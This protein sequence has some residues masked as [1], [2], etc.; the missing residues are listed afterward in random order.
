MG[1]TCRIVRFGEALIAR[2]GAVAAGLALA[3]AALLLGAPDA[4]AATY[5]VGETTDGIDGSPG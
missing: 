3:V 5:V 4:R 1:V 2:A